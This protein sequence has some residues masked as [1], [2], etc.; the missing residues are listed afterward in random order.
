MGRRIALLG[1]AA[2][3]ASCSLIT[4]FNADKYKENTE[5][6]CSDGLDNDGNGKIDC[7]DGTCD[8]FD[9]CSENSDA[10]CA[11]GLDNDMDKLVDCKDPGCCTHARCYLEPSCGEST[12]VAC[13]DGVDNDKNGLTDCADFACS[14]PSC[15]E[16]LRPVLVE[17]FSSSAQGCTV[18]QCP[19]ESKACCQDQIVPCNA[20]DSQRWMAWGLPRPLISKGR[21]VPNQP[22]SKCPASGIISTRDFTLSPG[23]HLEFRYDLKADSAA[24]LSVGLVEKAVVPQTDGTCGD[25]TARFKLLIGVRISAGKVWAMLG[26]VD[27]ASVSAATSGLS[28]VSLDV[29][30]KGKIQFNHQGTA[31][32]ATQ[33]KATTP[34]PLTRLVLQGHSGVAALD[35]VVTGYRNGCAA[36]KLWLTGPAG[37][38]PV[39]APSQETGLFDF[40]SVKSPSVVYDGVSYRIYYVGASTASPAVR[41][42]LAT[43]SDGLVWTRQQKP[44][45]ITGETARVQASPHVLRLAS[46][47][48]IMTYQTL[49]ATGRSIIALAS[50]SDGVAWTRKVTAVQ[51]GAADTWDEVEV[52]E[53]ALT[54]FQ[55]PSDTV[56]GLYLWYR[57]KGKLT[58]AG[59]NHLLPALGLAR[60]AMVSDLSAA[61]FTKHTGNPVLAPRT[62]GSDDR[63]LGDPWVMLDGKIL[64]M[65]YV[66]LTWGGQTQ[67]NLAASQDGIRWV[68][69]PKNPLIRA[70]GTSFFGSKVRGGPAVLD[71]WGTLNLWYGG[72]NTTGTMSI[73]H[74]VNRGK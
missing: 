11:D 2:L 8:H 15:C 46:N 51:R 28:S 67:L 61:V 42:G 24:N 63:G 22:C 43:S 23:L 27:A 70:G 4:D 50:S 1:L 33:L 49:D 36:P 10:R 7:S 53:P 32:Y 64:H 34:Y 45:E 31:F 29:N 16:Q 3:L 25:I 73:G 12:Q 71:Q 38:A 26:G 19:A 69:Y 68:R 9:F 52:G 41:I 62:G 72:Q 18:G 57:G 37:P 39:L 60:A 54:A 59:K 40:S 14:L 30:A 13:G 65:Y 21:F 74:V 35:D 66:G 48:W 56:P 5:E 47:N 55:G 44:L 58:T 17:T 6:N 20:F